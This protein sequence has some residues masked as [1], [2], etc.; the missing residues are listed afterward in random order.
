MTTTTPFSSLDPQEAG[1]APG[2]SKLAA[3]VAH[4]LNNPL[5]AVLRFVS[6]AQ[7]KAKTGNLSDVDRHL[8]D[9]QFGLQ[10]MT[11]VL[12]ELMDIGRQTHEV[13][14]RP[15]RLPLVELMTRAMRTNTGQAEQRGITLVVKNLLPPA[16]HPQPHHDL[17]VAQV[18][19]NILKN[20][21]EASP[22]HGTVRITVQSSQKASQHMLQIS[23]ED[24]GTGVSPEI[25][26]QLFV[27]FATSKPPGEGHGLGLAISRELMLSLGG[28]LTLDN[29]AA[30]ATGCVATL[31]LPFL[32]P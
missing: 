20:A 10:R 5:D 8:A 4:E 16:P 17:R 12:R 13:L 19:S 14:S 31:I 7:R 28:E 9:A 30:P 1:V 6:L 21:I 11:E 23:V 25:R 22:E 15:A 27:P 24:S 2:V 29:R 18:L 32:S 26:A 3:K